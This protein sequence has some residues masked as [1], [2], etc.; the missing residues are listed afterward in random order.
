[1]AVAATSGTSTA[2]C[3]WLRGR[4]GGRHGRWHLC[5]H[6]HGSN[7]LLQCIH[8]CHLLRGHPGH[9]GSE[10][11]RHGRE[12]PRPLVPGQGLPLVEQLH[13]QLQQVLRP[14]IS[15][16]LCLGRGAGRLHVRR[17]GL[18]GGRSTLAVGSGLR[19]LCRWRQLLCVCLKLVVQAFRHL[20][21]MPRRARTPRL[22]S[23][24]RPAP[25]LAL[26]ALG[27]R[28]TALNPPKELTLRQDLDLLASL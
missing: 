7:G 25:E 4:R 19:L 15:S 5:M 18:G 23:R 21:S 1:M 22:R 26:L 9:T 13:R 27:H 3:S 28:H 24:R 12:G 17:G 8:S 20:G 14:P 6:I 10:A 11:P 2:Q 16:C